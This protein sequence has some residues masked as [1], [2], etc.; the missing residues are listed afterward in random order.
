MRQSIL[1]EK[2]MKECSLLA[3][4]AHA[5][6]AADEEEVDPNTGAPYKAGLTIAMVDV[7][8][9]IELVGAEYSV[10]KKKLETI[11]SDKIAS[12][13]AEIQLKSSSSSDQEEGVS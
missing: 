6:S 11:F 9:L 7:L 12:V 2:L 4:M 13:E 5:A 10:D 3:N 1:L 8:A